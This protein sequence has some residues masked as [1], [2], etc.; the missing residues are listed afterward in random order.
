VRFI[1]PTF[2]TVDQA[3]I[4]IAKLILEEGETV[5]PR[6]LET[7]EILGWRFRLIN[8][9]AR[10]VNLR[11]R[12]WNAALAVGELCWHMAGSDSLE[13]ISYYSKNWDSVSDDGEHI[14]G[15]CYG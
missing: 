4:Q 8:P 2:E 11:P 12:K 7:R 1:P 14:R 3:L 5:F 10:T 13:F 6:G 9:R 15:S